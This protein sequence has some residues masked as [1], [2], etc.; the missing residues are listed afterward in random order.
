VKRTSEHHAHASVTRTWAT[1]FKKKQ[2]NTRTQR[3][4]AP[5]SEQ[6]TRRYTP[7]KAFGQKLSLPSRV[8][9]PPVCS[10]AKSISGHGTLQRLVALQDAAQF[11]RNYQFA[12]IRDPLAPSREPQQQSRDTGKRE[13]E[14]GREWK[15]VDA[16]TRKYR[17]IIGP[18][19]SWDLGQLC[20]P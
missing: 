1:N 8:R 4:R 19:L 17:P 18:T 10:D 9:S 6:A 14:S 3:E 11:R 2:K 20:L 7:L 5:C 16:A 13:E 12:P 15:R